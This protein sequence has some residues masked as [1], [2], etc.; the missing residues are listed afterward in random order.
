MEKIKHLLLG[1]TLLLM[2]QNQAQNATNEGLLSAS[3]TISPSKMF[4]GNESH[5]YL[6]GKLDYYISEKI[7]LTGEGFVYL[8]KLMSEESALRYNHN[9]FFGAS[10]HFGSNGHDFFICLQPG[11]AFTKLDDSATTTHQGVN[12]VV[13]LGAGYKFYFGNYFHFFAQTTY[14]TGKHTTDVPINLSEIRFAAGLGFNIDTL[15]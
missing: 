12:P 9:L 2:Y 3:L 6:D 10:R 4:C 14:V 1:I 7:A 8:G 11:L 13:G 5:F 15:K